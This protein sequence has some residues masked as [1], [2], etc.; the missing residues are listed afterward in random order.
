MIVTLTPNPSIDRTITVPQLAV[1]EVNRALGSRV[2][3]GGKGVNV[4]RAL[5][6]NGAEA[7]AVLPLGGPDG[8]WMAQALKADGVPH[9]V[10]AI[11]EDT[12][13]NVAIVD[14][15]GETTKVNEPGPAL[16]A[17]DTAAL[18]AAIPED[19]SFVA[20]CG[21]LPAGTDPD[22]LPALVRR[23]RGRAVVDTSGEPLA[24]AVAQGPALIK[25][26]AEELAELVG[27]ELLTIGD[28]VDAARSLV[29][30][31]VGVVV[32]SL[33]ADGAL[34]V[35]ADDLVFAHATVERPLST[36]GAGDC[37]LAGVLGALDAG[38]GPEQALRQGVAWGAASVS[39]P[40]S[41]VP[42]P[43]DIARTTVRSTT[44]PDLGTTLTH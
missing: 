40:G 2:D 20:L 36:V 39:L 42:G 27:R 34:W 4:A 26:N 22:F 1:G 35:D 11:P 29:A 37:L 23:F 3:P 33:G 24:R 5:V 15:D 41:A 31:G 30:S 7:L 12:R 6:R 14:A 10:V 25:P 8:A 18:A 44:E 19:A 28:V 13:T 9:H 16:S 43:E 17:D 32:A 38:K 21:S